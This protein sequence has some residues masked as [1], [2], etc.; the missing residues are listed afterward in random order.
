M[1]ILVLDTKFSKLTTL[2]AMGLRII[3]PLECFVAIKRDILCD[4]VTDVNMGENREMH[5]CT[6]N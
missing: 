2:R 6:R 5:F 3:A 4:D 1:V